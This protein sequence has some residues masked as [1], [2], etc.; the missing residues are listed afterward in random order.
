M[1]TLP[2]LSIDTQ[3]HRKIMRI[4]N[5]IGSYNPGSQG[6]ERVDP[7]A[8]T[9]DTRLHLSPL[10]VA[11]SNV[12]KNDVAAYVIPGLLRRKMFAALLQHYRQFQLVVELFSKV[13]RVDHRLFMSDDCIDILEEHNPRHYWVRKTCLGGLFVVFPEIA[14]GVK[15]LL[16][17]NRRL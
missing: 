11:R 17:H 9:E 7:L 16:G 4:G 14:R 12:I 10:D 1:R 15:K 13:L 6:T 5:F 2:R 3:F 8:K